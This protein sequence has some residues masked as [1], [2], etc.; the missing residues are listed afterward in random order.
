MQ[1]DASSKLKYQQTR[2]S[3]QHLPEHHP[4]PKYAD[5]SQEELQTL[6]QSSLWTR[7]SP[8]ASQITR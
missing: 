3:L 8:K 4:L 1:G 2:H 7:R 6:D 5:Q